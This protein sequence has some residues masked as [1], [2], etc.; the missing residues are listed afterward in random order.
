MTNLA[1]NPDDQGTTNFMDPF[2]IMQ[3]NFAQRCIL[4][5]QTTLAIEFSILLSQ[6]DDSIFLVQK[7]V[8]FCE[9][10]TIKKMQKFQ[11]IF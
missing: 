5:W 4:S 8:L 1:F 6:K 7:M 9:A 10:T 2:M 3:P 11:L